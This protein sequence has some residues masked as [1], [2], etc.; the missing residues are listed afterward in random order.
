MYRFDKLATLL[1]WRSDRRTLGDDV[2]KIVAIEYHAHMYML[3]LDIFHRCIGLAERTGVSAFNR[4]MNYLEMTF[5]WRVKL[6]RT[7]DDHQI[8]AKKP[9]TT[10]SFTFYMKCIIFV[11]LTG[12]ADRKRIDFWTVRTRTIQYRKR[13][14]L[15]QIVGFVISWWSQRLF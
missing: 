5:L 6:M 14:W 10:Y 13:V 7:I 12:Y 11:P 2:S 15:T 4:H 8:F 1:C 9:L 3:L